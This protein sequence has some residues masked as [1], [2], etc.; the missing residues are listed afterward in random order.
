M[1]DQRG[2]KVPGGTRPWSR[3]LKVRYCGRITTYREFILA[4]RRV[5]DLAA[6]QLCGPEVLWD[7]S[8]PRDQ[9]TV[10]IGS[11]D[12]LVNSIVLRMGAG[13]NLPCKPPNSTVWWPPR[14][15]AFRRAFANG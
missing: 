5:M 3:D 15:N 4:A 10:H 1:P 12:P 14:M 13:P 6:V 9:G 8:L 2:A 7:T 11:F